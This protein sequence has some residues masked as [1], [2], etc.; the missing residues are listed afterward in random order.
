MS[1]CIILLNQEQMFETNI[2]KIYTFTLIV[3]LLIEQLQKTFV[4]TSLPELPISRRCFF[5][6]NI[7]GYFLA[8]TI[9]ISR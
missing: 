2:I 6:F 1:V 4:C 7:L 5:M 3:A 8:Y 9:H